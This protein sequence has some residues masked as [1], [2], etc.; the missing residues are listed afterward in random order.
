MTAK[1]KLS[2]LLGIAPDQ[3]G[4][5]LAAIQTLCEGQGGRR[6][7][8]KEITGAVATALEGPPPV[9]AEGRRTVTRRTY[10]NGTA[11]SEPVRPF[12]DVGTSP[13]GPLVVISGRGT[14]QWGS[15]RPCD[16][17]GV[18][19]AKRWR[20]AESNRGIVEICA[21]CKP[22]VLDRSWGCVDASSVAVD[23]RLLRHDHRDGKREGFRRA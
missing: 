2:S 3:A 4:R 19:R 13:S 22:K 16:N 15:R 9:E 8:Y 20:Y 5:V 6:P 18:P 11:R 7:K 21:A 14:F 23:A 10:V 17:C 1:K 12:P